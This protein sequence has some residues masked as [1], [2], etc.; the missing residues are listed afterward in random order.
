MET[1]A[2]SGCAFNPGSAIMDFCNFL[3]DGQPNTVALSLFVSAAKALEYLKNS[4]VVFG[5]DAG[6]IIANADLMV[7]RSRN[8]FHADFRVA[9]VAHVFN[10]VTNQVGEDLI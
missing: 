9:A 10:R 2:F 6:A 7:A 8:D 3:D 5:V 1:C 4:F